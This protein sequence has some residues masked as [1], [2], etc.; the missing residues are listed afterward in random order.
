MD[1]ISIVLPEKEYEEKGF[2]SSFG[3]KRRISGVKKGLNIRFY[4]GY[5]FKERGCLYI[6]TP[7][8]YCTKFTTASKALSGWSATESIQH[9]L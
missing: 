5:E 9:I 2:D 8:I 4:K 3:K 1:T 6:I 7:C